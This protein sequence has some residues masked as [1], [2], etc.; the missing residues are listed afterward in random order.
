MARL[1]SA[2]NRS[3]R[4]GSRA[5]KSLLGT[6]D[7]A[8]ITDK[9]TNFRRHRFIFVSIPRQELVCCAFFQQNYQIGKVTVDISKGYTIRTKTGESES[10]IRRDLRSGTIDFD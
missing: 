9:P 3:G 8:A 10:R 4:L 2:R 1:S 7:T 5:C 6:S